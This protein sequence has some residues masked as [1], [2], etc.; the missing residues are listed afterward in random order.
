MECTG[1]GR[2]A[3]RVRRWMGC[4]V[5]VVLRFAAVLIGEK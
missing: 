3:T 2:S 1:I 4:S 5:S